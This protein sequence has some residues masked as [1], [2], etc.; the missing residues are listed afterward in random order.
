MNY[1]FEGVNVNNY[2]RV[3][4]ETD[5]AGKIQRAVNDNP[6]GVVVFPEGVYNI[7]KTININNRCSL[8]LAK[9]AKLV[10]VAEMEY[11]LDWDGGNEMFSMIMVCLLVEVLLT[12]LDCLVVCVCAIFII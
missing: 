9:N 8:K 12:G 3:V 5:D 7:G 11:A 1:E 2:E 6:N 4:G 10:C